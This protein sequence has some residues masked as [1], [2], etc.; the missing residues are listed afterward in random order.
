[1]QN[2]PT[3]VTWTR[4]LRGWIFDFYCTKHWGFL[5]KILNNLGLAFLNYFTANY[6]KKPT[7]L[8]SFALVRSP[9]L[10][11]Q[12]AHTVHVEK[13]D[14]SVHAG[15]HS[16]L[17][18][19]TP[20]LQGSSCKLFPCSRGAQ[21]GGCNLPV[22]DDRAANTLVSLTKAGWAPCNGCA[23]ESQSLAAPGWEEDTDLLLVLI[24]PPTISA[25]GQLSG[26]AVT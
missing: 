25:H 3:S 2:A 23:R 5:T 21:K 17:P 20:F 7:G 18:P 14:R 13:S 19:S 6:C 10:C 4:L 26:C 24:L 22:S 9:C 8:L 16:Q 12:H 1:M 15:W 11:N